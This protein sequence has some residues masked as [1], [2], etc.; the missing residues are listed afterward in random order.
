MVVDENRVRG[1]GCE[2][3][4][5]RKDGRGQNRWDDG[6]SRV[7]E[8]VV[9]DRSETGHER[10]IGGRVEIKGRYDEGRDFGRSRDRD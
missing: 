3:K 5:K 1:K 6:G 8:A 4:C 7:Q 10:H 2:W 9:N